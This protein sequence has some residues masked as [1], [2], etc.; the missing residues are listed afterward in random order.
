VQALALNACVSFQALSHVPFLV[1]STVAGGLVEAVKRLLAHWPDAIAARD[2]DKRTPLHI[3]AAR[4]DLN[5][6]WLIGSA[7]YG[8][9]PPHTP[10]PAHSIPIRIGFG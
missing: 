4:G 2:Y 9:P 6:V 7:E 3:A 10:P 5:M 1:C 8:A